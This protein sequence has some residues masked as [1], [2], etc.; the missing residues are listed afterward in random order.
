M[1]EAPVQ[2]FVTCLVDTLRP[3]VG[4]AAVSV[5]EEAGREV[6][7]P[8]G[9]G[10]C[11]QPAFNVGMWDE[12]REMASQT[13]DLLDDTKGPIVVPSGSCAAMMAHHYDQL[14][15]GTEREEQAHRVASRVREIT[16]F[17]VD[18][19]DSDVRADC[20]DCKV[21][22]HY[23]CHGLRTLGLEHQSDVL[24]E[25]IDRV[26]LE[27]DKVCCGFGGL[28]SVEMPA[29][30]NAILDEKIKHIQESGAGTLVGGDVSCLIHIEGGMRRKGGPTI[31]VKHIVELLGDSDG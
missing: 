24:L 5:L 16:E 21:A 7:V 26:P 29:V 17:L 19:L 4:R 15:A 10:C 20:G 14:F 12:A 2:L 11:G 8:S 23:S 22:V 13:L 18:D 6:N 28:F 31:E 25:D 30:S 9:Q 3:R 27:Q 1:P